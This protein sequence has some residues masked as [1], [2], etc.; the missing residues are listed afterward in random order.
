MTV[1]QGADL[2]M[3]WKQRVDRSPCTHPKLELEWNERGYLT[4]DYVCILCGE[5]VARGHLAA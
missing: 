5:S 3:K 2:Q 1:H 4:G